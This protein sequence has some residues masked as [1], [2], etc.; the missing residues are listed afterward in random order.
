MK[1]MMSGL[2]AEWK[3]M[4]RVLERQLALFESPFSMRTGSNGQDT[5]E[6]TRNRVA[7]CIDELNALLKAHNA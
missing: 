7:R 2:I 4:K 3:N 1:T 6:E 5:T